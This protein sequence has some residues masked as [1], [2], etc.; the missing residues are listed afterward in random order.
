MKT[1]PPIPDGS[2]GTADTL[3]RAAERGDEAGMREAAR[4]FEGYLVESMLKSMRAASSVPGGG[5]AMD[6][7]NSMFDTEIATRIADGPGLGLADSLM[8][9][10]RARYGGRGASPVAEVLGGGPE[11]WVWPL[12]RDPSVRISSGFGTRAAPVAGASTDHKGLDIA[13]PAGTVVR[14]MADGVVRRAGPASGFGTLLEIEH[15]DGVVSR[16]AHQS[17]IDV[18]PGHRVRAGDPVGLVGSE[19]VSSGAHLHL[20]IRVDGEAVDPLEWLRAGR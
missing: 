5:G 17:R 19:G 7:W 15:D 4:Q 12:P 14:A 20:E 11:G 10:M 18:E 3:R 16:Y 8:E 13:A 6:T 2:N 9:G 1:L